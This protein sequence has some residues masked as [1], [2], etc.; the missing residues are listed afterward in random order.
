MA[1]ILAFYGG[2]KVAHAGVCSPGRTARPCSGSVAD[3][4]SVS[5][6]QME[7]SQTNNHNLAWLNSGQLPCQARA[8]KTISKQ[9]VFPKQQWTSLWASKEASGGF[10]DGAI[11]RNRSYRASAQLLVINV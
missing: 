8:A 6:D 5:V 4:E 7:A 10:W 3:N 9:L 11:K 2:Q 1:L